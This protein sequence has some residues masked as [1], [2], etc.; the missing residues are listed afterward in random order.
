MEAK[1]KKSTVVYIFV[2]LF[3]SIAIWFLFDI[4]KNQNKQLYLNQKIIKA[5]AEFTAT[6]NGY[7]M[8][9][10]FIENK[11]FT[12]PDIL[13]I[14]YRGIRS[15][16]KEKY[17]KLL[18]TKLKPLYAEMK[19][20]GINYLQ[21]KLPDGTVFFSL[22]RPE[23]STEKPKKSFTIIG[24]KQNRIT[25]GFRFPFELYFKGHFLG[26]VEIAI[27]YDAIKDQL[28]KIF[29][30]EYRF[31]LHKNFLFNRLI[32]E[33]R[34]SYIQSEIDPDFYYESKLERDYQ[35][36]PEIFSIINIKLKEKTKNKLSEFKNFAVDVKVNGD[37][38]VVS[39]IVISNTKGEKIGYLAYYEKDNTI[40]LFTE[41]FL[42]MYGSVEL[43]LFAMLWLLISLI[44]KSEKFRTLS[45]I[46]ALTGI[47]NKGKFNNVLDTEL[48]KV[49][50][51][52][53]P[54]GLILFDIDH[55]KQINDTFGHQV[56]DYVLKTIADIVK[57]NI[58][59]TDI[60]A[61]W[62]GEEFVIL[63]PETD[64]NGL[65]M[66]AEKLRKA[67]ENHNFEKVKKVTASFG[68]T[69]AIPEDTTDT[70]VR[71]AD[72][73]LYLAKEKGRNRVEIVLPEV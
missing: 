68:L 60:F 34:K 42:M 40:F 46:D 20:Y 63:A 50:R 12:D 14:I 28:R 25:G 26:N 61:R 67:I 57:K 3:L 17:R 73:A 16:D 69:E 43:A 59:D 21:I 48:K 47:Y 29:K 35:I 53:R 56:G 65:K 49:R 15:P 7:K 19:K 66:L 71:R 10:D 6:L 1:I 33:E 30:G 18:H 41:T 32:K 36:N 4:K 31:L 39:F 5:A 27:S 52:K 13:N 22:H 44:T 72:E 55:F 58:R 54:M 62:G 45:E 24:S 37:Y 64:I 23:R 38:Y 9:V 51:Y 11:Y 70:V 2:F 8:V